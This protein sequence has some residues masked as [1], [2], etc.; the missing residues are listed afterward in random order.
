[1]KLKLLKEIIE[2]LPGERTV[3]RYFKDRYALLLLGYLVGNGM[4]IRQIRHS[5]LAALLNKPV[6]REFLATLGHGEVNRQ[7]IDLFWQDEMYS[8]V[9]TIDQWGGEK[10]AWDQTS[11]QGHN[12]VLQLNF[13]NQHDGKY[14]KLVKP[15]AD[16]LLNHYGHPVF[17]TR[18]D[19]YVR[20]TLAWARIDLDFQTD[21]ALIEEIQSDWVREARLLFRDARWYLKNGYDRMRWWDLQGNLDD[22]V[23][24]CENVLKPYE[25]IWSEAMLSAAID[26]IRTEL[27]IRRIFYHSDT[28]GY[29]VKRIRYTRPPKSLYNKLPRQFCFEKTGDAPEFLMN[30]KG[31]RRLYRKVTD[32][33]WY[34]MG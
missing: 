7:D 25:Q 20:E 19:E 11:R 17:S 32:P 21:E 15:E 29:R 12:L 13:S 26:F 23:E 1:M 4:D 9:L 33:Q 10:P 5:R 6:M 30:D 8:F 31:F 2:C 18:D 3:F 28:T 27:G 14:K 22:V 16:R 34:C 24:Y